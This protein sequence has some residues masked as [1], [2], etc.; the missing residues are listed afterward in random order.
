MVAK[1]RPPI[2]SSP[3][4][5]NFAG[6]ANQDGWGGAAP[7]ALCFFLPCSDLGQAKTTTS[8][9]RCGNASFFALCDPPATPTLPPARLRTSW[10]L[11]QLGSCP[12]ERHPAR[13]CACDNLQL[14]LTGPGRL[15]LAWRAPKCAYR[16]TS[17]LLTAAR[18]AATPR[19]PR[20]VPSW[21]VW[22]RN[23]RGGLGKR[24]HDW[25]PESHG[26]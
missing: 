17:C 1:P 8:G 13:P 20:Q 16:L 9:P 5:P 6:T 23:A 3:L 4:F 15:L 19:P 2:A 18:S 21:R 24:G 12:D 14:R 11:G 10:D 7:H 25:I 26:V 22:L